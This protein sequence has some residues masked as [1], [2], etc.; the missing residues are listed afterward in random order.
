MHEV[1]SG[2]DPA[3]NKPGDCRL[4]EHYV[5]ADQLAIELSTHPPSPPGQLDGLGA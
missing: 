5:P 4:K 2:R 3:E 1:V